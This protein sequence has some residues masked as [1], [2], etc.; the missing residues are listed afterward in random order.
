[1]YQSL[2]FS[3]QVKA[4]NSLYQVIDFIIEDK[5]LKYSQ[6]L[7]LLYSYKHFLECY[8][9]LDRIKAFREIQTSSS[10]QLKN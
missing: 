2:Q 10:S 9:G 1:M 8:L 6:L 3:Q 4:L 7:N 5:F